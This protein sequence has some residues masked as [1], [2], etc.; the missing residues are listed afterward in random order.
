MGALPH[1][2][3]AFTQGLALHDGRFYESTGLYGASTVR[4]VE[5]ATGN[6]V[7]SVALD[8]EYFGEGLEVVGDRIVQLT[9]K[10][11]T[12]FVW[13]TETLEPLGSYY[14]EGEGWGLCATVNHFVMSNGSSRLTFRDLETFDA[15]G[16]VDVLLAGEPVDNL[17]ELECIE[18]LVYANVWMTDEI[19]VIAPESGQVVTR[20]DASSLRGELSSN[21]GIDVL[22]GI[23]YDPEREIFYLTGKLWPDIFEVHITSAS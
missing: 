19:M 6:V 23:A 11:E 3:G 9:W 12:A 22:N 4:I 20:I 17:N 16:G 13:D 15:V 1:D 14:Y 8:D 5:L 18:G 10:E 7:S 2:P 21:E